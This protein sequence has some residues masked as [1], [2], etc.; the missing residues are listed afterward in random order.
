M[1]LLKQFVLILSIFLFS[2]NL[3]A[4]ESMMAPSDD[5]SSSV[6]DHESGSFKGIRRAVVVGVNEYQ[7]LGQL[8][9]A[10]DDAVA[11]GKSL[12]NAGFDQRN[13]VV[14]HDRATRSLQPDKEKIMKQIELMLADAKSEDLVFLAFCMHGVRIGGKTYLA[15]YEA[16]VP[17]FDGDQESM[18]SFIPMDWVYE[19]L[20]NCPAKMK[21]M[22]VDACQERIFDGDTRSL[23]AEQKSLEAINE[24]ESPAGIMQM[25]A[26]APGE[27]SY[28]SEKLGHGVYTH[29]LL[30]ALDGKAD[31][32]H[33]GIVTLK[34][35]DLYVSRETNAYVR[36]QYKT[37]QRP[38]IKGEMEGD[39]PLA[40]AMRLA[41]ITF[42]Q[43]IDNLHSALERLDNGG[44]LTIQLGTHRID[45][46]LTI[47]HDIQIVGATGDPAD[48]T[49]ECSNGNC[50]II[51]AEN[52]KI[53][54]LTLKTTQG[55]DSLT[56]AAVQISAGRSTLHKCS[57]TSA[58]SVGL[59]VRGSSANPTL[60][61]CKIFSCGKSGI[62]VYEN[63]K[64][65]FN[66][67]DVYGN[68]LAG[69]EV[70]D[71][72]DPQ[73]TGCK[74]YDGKQCGIFVYENGKGTFNNC[75]AHGNTL[76]G[77]AV[78][79]GGDPQ[80]TGCKF[81]NGK[82]TGIN[83][84][85][86]GKGTFNNC[87]AYGN[88][89]SGIQVSEG[90]D[91]QVTGCKFYDSKQ[92]CGIYVWQ[93][94][95]GTFNNCE[96]YGNAF[97]GI[98]VKDGGDPQVTGCKFYDSKQSCGIYVWQTGKGTFNNCEAYGNTNSGIQ[99]SKGGDPQ[100]TGCKFYDGKGS[101]IYVYEN[102][103]GTF[104][105]CEAY[106]N[107]NNGINVRE[108][109]NPTI[110]NCTV[111]DN[112]FGIVIRSN[113]KGTYTGNTLSGNGDG[114]WYLSNPGQIRRSGNRPNQ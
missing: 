46:P 25:V 34:E 91:P 37:T 100:V 15:P 22:M 59:V 94:G 78:K 24:L 63:G 1:S 26:C 98:E 50:L 112:Q 105:N 4:Q 3:S 49:I 67:C 60:T 58:E 18:N 27:Y 53:Q 85:T 31:T 83:V 80:V 87:D 61:Q 65:I 106:R 11:L 44:V 82:S 41:R 111:R 45:K 69:I 7:H 51:T 42:P 19:Q 20:K 71:G 10:G 103:K 43:D 48:V 70:K 72:G 89:L 73:V 38:S 39:L 30:E 99:V 101:G 33:D 14:I 64:G 66:N 35:V 84:S 77:I 47:N 110:R 36:E 113:G 102:G 90:G 107:A 56:G 5:G 8:R 28:E 16:K 2:L 109:G 55:S 92:S 13:V 57:M 86:N 96:A 52:A 114:N 68:T 29:F 88:T 23:T 81:Y 95:K 32:N 12:I 75:E 104:D 79:E 108:G 21:L 76:S 6:S 74:F 9:F 40:E 93:T 97:S 17:K 62:F 54:G